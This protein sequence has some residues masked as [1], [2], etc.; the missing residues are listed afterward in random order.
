[1]EDTG[2]GIAEDQIAHIFGEFHQVENERN[3]Q[4]DGTGLG[5]T[6]CQRLVEMM[7]G[8]VW[9]TSQEGEGAC[10]GFDL[11]M[12]TGSVAPDQVARLPQNVGHVLI[13]DDIATNRT[14]LE[15][16]LRQVGIK[17]TACSSGPEALERMTP[18]VDL[19]LTDHNMPDM[20]GM[21]LARA[22]RGSGYDGP[23]LLLSSNPDQAEQDPARGL[24]QGCCKSPCQGLNCSHSLPRSA[25]RAR[26]PA[27]WRRCA[28]CAFSRQRTTGPTNWSF[29]R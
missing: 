3:R 7:G 1:M 22:L 27:R 29:A 18:Q 19:V 15:R 6:I 2:I 21:E 13:V 17:V 9:V 12:P 5:L 4:F 20:D 24:I 28:Q 25:R 10:F 26:R 16:Q 8:K 23:I 14:I 11:T